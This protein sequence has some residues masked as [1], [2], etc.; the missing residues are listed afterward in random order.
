MKNTL[1][2]LSHNITEPL[3][4]PDLRP[5][6]CHIT[7]GQGYPLMERLLSKQNVREIERDRFIVLKIFDAE[8]SNI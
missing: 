6:T 1:E 7:M 8:K 3:F 2:N 4:A 5:S